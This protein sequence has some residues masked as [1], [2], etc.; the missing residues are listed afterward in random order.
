ML[1]NADDAGLSAADERTFLDRAVAALVGASNQP[2]ALKVAVLLK[3]AAEVLAQENPL[4]D[5]CRHAAFYFFRLCVAAA[6]DAE[7]PITQA[8]I[9][10]YRAESLIRGRRRAA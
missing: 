7:P 10:A 8:A 3:V 6:H 9:E 5:R 1:P 4:P 2:A